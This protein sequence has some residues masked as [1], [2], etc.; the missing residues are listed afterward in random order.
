MVHIR[1]NHLDMSREEKRRF[2]H[3]VREIKRRGIYD[4]FVALHIRINSTDYLDKETGK[5]LG[6][7]NPGFLPWHRQYL[8]RFERALQRVDPRV[9]LPYWDWTF[10][11][12][13]DSPLWDEE[14]M[15]GNGRPGDRR[16]M[17]GPFARDNGWVLNVSVIPVGDEDPALNGHFT[18]DDRDFLVRDMGTLTDKLPTPKELDDTLALPVYDCPPWNHTAGGEAPFNSFRNHLEGYTKFPWEEKAG[19]LHAAGHVWVGGHM[20]YIGSPND[21][22]FFLNHCMIDRCWALWQERNPHVPHYLPLTD[23]PDVPDLHTRLGPWHTMT[24]ADLIDHTKW[25]RYA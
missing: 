17:T 10:D 21:P 13:E 5:R 7:I 14:F 12:G 23:T 19:K 11:H 16:V 22:V 3:A 9:T 1:K 25:Y 24:P 15:G 20:M 18:H 6:H 4:R 2:V 8:L